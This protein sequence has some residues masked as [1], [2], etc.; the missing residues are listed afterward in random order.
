MG[1]TLD[2]Y[3]DIL[4]A[5]TNGRAMK[6]NS[7]MVMEY[8]FDRDSQYQVGYLYDY[9]HDVG[10]EKLKLYNLHPVSDDNK[11]AIECKM[12]AHTTQTYSKDNITFHLEFKP[13]QKCNVPYYE[14][15]L[16]KPYDAKWPIGLYV[17]LMD[18]KENY[19][20]WLIVGTANYWNVNFPTYEILQCDRVYQW[21]HR[22][23]K[24]QCAG[25]RRSQSSYNQGLWTD[26]KFTSVEDQDK[27]ILPMNADTATIFYNHRMLIDNKGVIEPR[28]WLVSKI[29]RISP[30][31][32]CH[33]TV[34]QDLYDPH[35][36]YIEKDE[37]GNVIGMWADYYDNQLEPQN[38]EAHYTDDTT[39]VQDYSSTISFSGIKPQLKVG[40][41]FKIFTMEYFDE[42]G[43]VVDY[44]C[45]WNYK[46]TDTTIDPGEVLWVITPQESEDLA[47]NQVKIKFV[48]SEEYYGE[49]LTIYNEFTSLEVAIVGM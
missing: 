6:Y 49:I 48:G 41:S 37:F 7:D 45:T 29:N 24:Y 27:F 13:S 4:G 1:I 39:P 3:G 35:K 26:H 12:V 30:N 36:D 28:A 47:D 18:E 21:I 10:D 38:S 44:P 33:V 11:I 43:N 32:V 17:D 5:D 46:F 23:K 42:S 8:T 22:G 40:G 25:A 14:D 16:G 9:Y 20:R 34:K 19:N 15:S 2:L 31:G